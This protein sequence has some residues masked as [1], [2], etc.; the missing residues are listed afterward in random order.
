ML[1]LPFSYNRGH[2]LVQRSTPWLLLWVLSSLSFSRTSLPP[3]VTSALTPFSSFSTDT[4]VVSFHL[5]C[6]ISDFLH[7]KLNSSY[8]TLWP[9]PIRTPL[10]HSLAQQNFSEMLSSL[11][12]S[13]SSSPFFSHIHSISFHTEKRKK[14]CSCQGQPIATSYWTSQY[15]WQSSWL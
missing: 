14:K 6:C 8:L 10:H 1:Y 9:F 11:S 2:A 4:Q 5:E 12:A 13:T 7:P 3:S 15:I